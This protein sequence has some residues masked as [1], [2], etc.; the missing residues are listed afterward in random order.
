MKLKDAY[1]FW[2]SNDFTV[3][4]VPKHWFN[5]EP[6]REYIGRGFDVPSE[7]DLANPAAYL[8]R[9][10]VSMTCEVGVNP[11]EVAKAFSL[12]DEFDKLTE[13]IG[14]DA[15]VEI[16]RRRRRIEREAA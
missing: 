14:H 1:I 13:D 3:R 11:D 16:D 9:E 15:E 7:S 10:F 6:E 12:I 4:V 2:D 8:L 5:G